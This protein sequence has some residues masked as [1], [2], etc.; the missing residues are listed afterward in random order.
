MDR[1]TLMEGKIKNIFP[2]LISFKFFLNAF[3]A[4]PISLNWLL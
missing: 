4:G 1:E 2:V 3:L